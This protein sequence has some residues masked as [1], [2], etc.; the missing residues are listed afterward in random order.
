MVAVYSHA[1]WEPDASYVV[2]EDQLHSVFA[3]VVEFT[4]IGGVLIMLVRREP[5]VPVRVAG[6]LAALVVACAT[7]M[8]MSTPVWGIVQRFMFL[9]A[10]LW[11]AS[12]ALGDSGP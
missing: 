10:A 7:P 2:L 9:T 4:F 3:S 11:Y 12:E 6:D 5:R 1:P 8:L